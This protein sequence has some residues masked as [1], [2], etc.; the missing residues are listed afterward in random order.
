MLKTFEST[1]LKKE[2]IGWG[3]PCLEA[4]PVAFYI[5]SCFVIA[6]FCIF[7]SSSLIRDDFFRITHHEKVP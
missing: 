7:L 6:A 3:R 5:T 1:D 4:V 2:D